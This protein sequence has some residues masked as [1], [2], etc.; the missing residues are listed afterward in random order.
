MVSGSIVCSSHTVLAGV[1]HLV[2][3]T[4]HLWV[5]PY[6]LWQRVPPLDNKFVFL[7]IL[8]EYNPRTFGPAW[9]ANLNLLSM[10]QHHGGRSLDKLMISLQFFNKVI[11]IILQGITLQILMVKRKAITH[12]DICLASTE[13]L[14]CNLPLSL[15][16]KSFSTLE[17]LFF[18]DHT[19]DI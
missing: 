19:K 15:K 9:V 7:S 10:T 4:T 16:W 1:V 14:F 18:M 8:C 13:G 11:I 12:R 17:K 6:M 5:P 2:S 3:Y